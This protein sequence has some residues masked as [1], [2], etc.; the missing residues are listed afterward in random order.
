MEYYHTYEV[1]IKNFMIKVDFVEKQYLCLL[2][3]ID[4][5]IIDWLK[6]LVEIIILE[7]DN[8]TFS[9]YH[10]SVLKH[11]LIFIGIISLKCL[12]PYCYINCYYYYS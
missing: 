1:K 11:L 5:R 2:K 6:S 4:K 3:M 9:W 8:K 12:F 10:V 7:N